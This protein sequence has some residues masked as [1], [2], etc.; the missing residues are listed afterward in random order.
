MTFRSIFDNNPDPMIAFDADA[1]VTRANSAAG[2][3]LEIP[4]GTVD[5]IAKLIPEGPGQTL[6]DCQ[7][8]YVLLEGVYQART[9]GRASLWSGTITRIIRCVKMP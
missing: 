8:A 6:E 4:Y 2:R 9:A 1:T 7:D 3:V 5:K